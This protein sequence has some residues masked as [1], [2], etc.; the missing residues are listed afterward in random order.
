MHEAG[1]ELRRIQFFRALGCIGIAMGLRGL[2]SA[3]K[4]VA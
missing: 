1:G 4:I 2:G 3:A